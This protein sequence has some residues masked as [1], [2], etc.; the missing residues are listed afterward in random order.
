MLSPLD[1]VRRGSGASVVKPRL[2]LLTQ[3][4]DVQVR[5]EIRQTHLFTQNFLT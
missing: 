3:L 2:C 1:P 5:F 4:E